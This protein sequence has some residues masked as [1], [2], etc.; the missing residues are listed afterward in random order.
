M[1]V[2]LL[3]NQLELN[4]ANIKLIYI[5]LLKI[6]GTVYFLSVNLRVIINALY[7]KIFIDLNKSQNFF[8]IR[9]EQVFNVNRV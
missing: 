5:S 3:F 1:Y 7:Y 9:Y 2:T 8:R 4:I 6:T